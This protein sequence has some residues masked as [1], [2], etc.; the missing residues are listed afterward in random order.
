MR[1]LFKS[2]PYYTP[3]SCGWFANKTIPKLKEIEVPVLEEGRNS[4]R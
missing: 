3:L 4:G 1:S 2:K